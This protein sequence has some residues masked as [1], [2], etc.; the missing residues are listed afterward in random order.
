M[1]MVLAALTIVAVVVAAGTTIWTLRLAREDRRRS[2]AR[3]AMLERDII[4]ATPRPGDVHQLFSAGLPAG[5][6][7][8]RLAIA[9][10]LGLLLIVGLTAAG[11]RLGRTARGASPETQVT[12]QSDHQ[13]LE[14]TSLRHDRDGT[15]WSIV[16]LVRNPAGGAPIDRVT[17]VAFLFDAEGAF[18]SSGREPL[19]F[20]TLAAGTESPFAIRITTPH[21][22]ARYRVGFR[23]ADG[24]VIRHIDRRPEITGADAHV[25]TIAP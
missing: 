5:G 20:A 24:S 11:L 10:V 21:R 23:T 7:V 9:F 4:E 19:E 12:G 2:D 13:P 3:V 25:E 1:N 15:E 8:P 16:G 14:L 6:D 17:A 18:L 22:V